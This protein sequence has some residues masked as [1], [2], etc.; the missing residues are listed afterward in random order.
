MDLNQAT[1]CL[2]PVPSLLQEKDAKTIIKD[3]RETV[4]SKFAQALSQFKALKLQLESEV[5]AES[6]EKIKQMLQKEAVTVVS[7]KANCVLSVAG[8]VTDINRLN[9]TLNGVVNTISKR[10]HRK[11]ESITQGI[12][13]SRSVFHILCLDGLKDK[14][15]SVYPELEMSFKEGSL[16]LSVTGLRD[17]IF[18]AN[19]VI[20]DAVLALKRQNLEKDKFVL[21]LLKD[22]QA[23]ELTKVLLTSNGINATFEIVAQ[24]VQLLAVSERDLNNAEDHLEKLLISKFLDVEDSNVLKKPEWKHLVSQLENANNKPGRRIRI[25]TTG[26]Q[27]VVSGYTGSVA[28]VSP[29]LDDFLTQNAQVEETIVVTPNALV[30][31]LKKHRSLEQRI[32]KV[33][34]SYQKEAICLTGSRVDVAKCKTL[35]EDTVSSVYF[36]SLKVLKPGAK[37]YFKENKAM[38]ISS[39]LTET[40]CLV[41][42]VDEQDV[43]AQRQVPQPAYQLQTSDGVEI[44][45]CNAD[46]CSYPVHAVVSASTGDL[47]HQGGLAGA[48][49]KAAG[50]QLQNECD[51]LI[52]TK[53][54]IKPG[55]CVITGAGGLQCCKKV[56][57]AVGPAYD[58]VKPQK[59]IA[60]LKKVV[61]ESLE[62]AEEN[63]CTSVALPAISKNQ[64]FPLKLCAETIV[65]AVKE[66]CDEKYDDNTLKKIHFV[67]NEVGTV[68][69]MEAA[70]RQEF[71][72]H[73]VSLSQQAPA[74]KGNKPPPA[75]QSQT[76]QNHLNEVQTKEG[77]DIILMKG[78]IED[79][80]V[81][82][83]FFI[84]S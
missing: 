45:V 83:F 34:V 22:E 80:K 37:K 29:K 26:Q 51:I 21:D 7:D 16:D 25:H 40:G 10:V 66:H 28:A 70:V 43:S 60:L 79:S 8:L 27:V 18:A 1:V 57:H 84:L 59:A 69:A 77:L 81:L 32:D 3:W 67:N 47:K 44:A 17:E 2:S 31:Y 65:K 35:A 4:K 61:K 49:F 20:C 63:G 14:L 19:K 64:N 12:R 52:N 5:W 13:V 73:G 39:L 11:R 46:M 53:G 48:L 24:R 50:P 15:L 33:Q 42:L 38:Y 76:K 74:S 62:L 30:E 58:Q 71:G 72:N 41:Q 78:N 23:E 68:Q 9:E 55:D 54:N 36:E 56:I 82:L 6:V 75:K